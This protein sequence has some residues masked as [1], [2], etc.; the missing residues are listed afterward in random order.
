MIEIAFLSLNQLSDYENSNIANYNN[1][2]MIK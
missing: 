1:R 2:V